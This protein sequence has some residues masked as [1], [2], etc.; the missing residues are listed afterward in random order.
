M[1]LRARQRGRHERNR[2]LYRAS[3]DPTGPWHPGTIIYEGERLTVVAL[4]DGTTRHVFDSK[5]ELSDRGT[6]LN[7]DAVLD[8]AEDGVNQTGRL[9]TCWKCNGHGTLF[10]P[11]PVQPEITEQSPG[12]QDLTTE[13]Y[14]LLELIELARERGGL[15][16]VGETSKDWVSAYA[17]TDRGNWFRVDK[18]WYNI[19]SMTALE[20]QGLI[21]ITTLKTDAALEVPGAVFAVLHLDREGRA[22][23]DW[24]DLALYRPEPTSDP[25]G[26]PEQAAM[27]DVLRVA[28]DWLYKTE[29][30][31]GAGLS[32]HGIGSVNLPT[33]LNRRINLIPGCAPIINI[34][35][36]HPV[37]IS[38]FEVRNPLA[39]GELDEWAEAIKD[40]GYDVAEV[41]HSGGAS[42][43]IRLTE[44]AHPSLLA[45]VELYAKGCPTHPDG[46]SAPGP[47]LGG[48]FCRCGWWREQASLIVY[49]K[50]PDPANTR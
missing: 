1:T 46:D 2:V 38:T 40:L 43:G 9:G 4:D 6:G 25:Y 36:A 49:P 14:R 45:A 37:K 33:I 7:G 26:K 10:V 27:A 5:N 15:Y 28:L 22:T 20:T 34:T 17:C 31:T 30:P 3:N 19:A 41:F 42:G 44:Q 13:A 48:V 39:P 50:Y 8:I 32:H 12:V 47:G 18:A 21:T 11:D 29:Q 16:L 23:A 24:E 35:V